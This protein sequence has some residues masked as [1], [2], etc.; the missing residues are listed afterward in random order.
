MEQRELSVVVYSEKGRFKREG[1]Y[2]MRGEK[3]YWNQ[4]KWRRK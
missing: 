2:V 4:R 3:E 1:D